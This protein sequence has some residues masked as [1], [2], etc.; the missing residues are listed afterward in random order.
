MGANQRTPPFD[1]NR[2]AQVASSTCGAVRIEARG[3]PR[4]DFK[5]T[6]VLI[7]FEYIWVD[8]N[9]YPTA[10]GTY[11]PSSFMIVNRLS[12]PA[13]PEPDNL[14]PKASRWHQQSCASAAE[15]P[16]RTNPSQAV[17]LHPTNLVMTRVLEQLRCDSHLTVIHEYSLS[18]QLESSI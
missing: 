15:P 18:T 11:S 5:S 3:P 7:I 2:R 4:F 1:A 6:K 14:L 10:F 8:E 17:R 16:T 12:C 9:Q 13:R